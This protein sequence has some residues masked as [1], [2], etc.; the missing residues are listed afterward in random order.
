MAGGSPGRIPTWDP[1]GDVRLPRRS[2]VRVAGPADP[3][4]PRPGSGLRSGV[5]VLALG[6]IRLRRG[7]RLQLLGVGVRVLGC[8]V[9]LRVS[10]VLGHGRRMHRPDRS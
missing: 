6:L 8:V 2:A 10:G 9:L 4:E 5:V 3:R 7:A 1:A